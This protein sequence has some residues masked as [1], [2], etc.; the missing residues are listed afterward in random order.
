M[1]PL[2]WEWVQCAVSFAR[3]GKGDDIKTKVRL[4]EITVGS[5]LGIRPGPVQAPP[6]VRLGH[7]SFQRGSIAPTS[8]SLLKISI[9]S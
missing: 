7:I 8:K 2:Y 4:S 9:S 1:R 6:V 3:V 5:D